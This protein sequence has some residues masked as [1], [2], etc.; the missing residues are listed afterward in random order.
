MTQTSK[1]QM[2]R[3]DAIDTLMNSGNAWAEMTACVMQHDPKINHML[4]RVKAS[5]IIKGEIT[6]PWL[7]S[8]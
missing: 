5:R 2:T 6:A 1:A 8:A 4:A 7:V 3:D